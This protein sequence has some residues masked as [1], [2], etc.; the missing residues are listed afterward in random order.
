MKTEPLK[1]V[2]IGR[3]DQAH[4][5]IIWLHGLGADGNDFVPIA[6]ELKLPQDTKIHFVFPHAPIRPVSLN[7]GMPMRAWFDLYTLDET[8][9]CDV[10]GIYEA[11]A[12]IHQLIDNEIEAGI[13]S[14]R[15]FLAGFSQGG[16]TALL[17]GLFYPKKLGGLIGLSTFLWKPEDFEKRLEPANKT[18][19]IFLAH[20][21]NDALLPLHYGDNAAHFFKSEGYNVDYHIYSMAHTVCSE[22]I[23]AL[24]RWLQRSFNAV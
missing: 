16:Y 23:E 19:P 6:P 4:Y 17:S 11:I 2:E 8:G 3:A 15:I 14:N 1:T 18:T 24:S 12:N 5:S 9:M 20:G 21:K 13:P 10:E 7:S 22:E